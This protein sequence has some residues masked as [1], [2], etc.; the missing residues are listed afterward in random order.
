MWTAELA[1]TRAE[2]IT[3]DWSYAMTAQP[4]RGERERR[5]EGGRDGESA[6]ETEM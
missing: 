6:R 3:D 2:L 1:G 4:P 5:R